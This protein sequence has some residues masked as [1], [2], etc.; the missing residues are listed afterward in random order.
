MLDRCHRQ[1]AV[2]H[3]DGLI[4]PTGSVAVR[5]PIDPPPRRTVTGS[6]KGFVYPVTKNKRSDTL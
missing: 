2:D 3:P 1:P 4:S 6:F 5:H